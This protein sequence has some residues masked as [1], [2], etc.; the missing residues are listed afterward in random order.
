[1]IEKATVII[2]LLYLPCR[3]ITSIYLLLSDVRLITFNSVLNENMCSLDLLRKFI[4]N[5]SFLFSYRQTISKDFVM[6]ELAFKSPEECLEFL[7]PFSLVFTDPER[8]ILDCK[9]SMALLPNI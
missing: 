9:N 1:M 4:T 3:I 8:T 6:Q 5:L 7:E 2:H